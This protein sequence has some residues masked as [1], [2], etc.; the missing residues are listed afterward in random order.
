MT[1]TTRQ[2][3]EGALLGDVVEAMT[4]YDLNIKR[5]PSYCENIVGSHLTRCSHRTRA[6]ADHT[7]LGTAE[8]IW[9]G[10]AISYAV[11]LKSRMKDYLKSQQVQPVI[12]SYDYD[13]GI[14]VRA[15]ILESPSGVLNI[16]EKL[17]MHT[18]EALTNNF[19][20]HKA[21]RSYLG[22]GAVV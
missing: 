16:Q 9:E 12:E 11:L 22:R 20:D 14:L 19:G 7:L 2:L 8:V 4:G 3:F 17:F 18:I 15:F 5:S 10:A 1:R 6:Y 21:D 13:R